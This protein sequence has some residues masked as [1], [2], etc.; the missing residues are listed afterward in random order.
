MIKK[1]AQG[2]PGS[3]QFS[4]TLELGKVTWDQASPDPRCPDSPLTVSPVPVM[5]QRQRH[6]IHRIICGNFSSMVVVGG[7]GDKLIGK[8]W[9]LFYFFPLT[10][11]SC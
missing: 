2:I 1:Y 6:L 10:H 3:D 5:V 11:L 4:G 8:K 7:E 9:F